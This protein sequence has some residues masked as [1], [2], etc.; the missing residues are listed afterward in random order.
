MARELVLKIPDEVY[1]VLVRAA[2]QAGTTP[3][4][5]AVCWLT[6]V[7]RPAGQDPLEGFIGAFPGAVSD[8]ADQHDTYLGQALADQLRGEPPPG[9]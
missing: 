4:A 7:S 5:L 6:A 8:W 9:G 2:Q 1:E 3:E